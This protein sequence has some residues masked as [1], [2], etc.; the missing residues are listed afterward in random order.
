M[1]FVDDLCRPPDICGNRGTNEGDVAIDAGAMMAARMR[2]FESA[3]A[4]CGQ[5]GLSS[6]SMRSEVS[7]ARLRLNE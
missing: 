5:E 3:A 4:G 6:L 7:S 2:S 1:P